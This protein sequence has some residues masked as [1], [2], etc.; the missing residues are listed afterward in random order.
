[1]RRGT[2]GNDRRNAETVQ[3]QVAVTSGNILQVYL[4]QKNGSERGQNDTIVDKVCCAYQTAIPRTH[5]IPHNQV[6]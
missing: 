5:A 1:M 4:E 2:D 3:P 6:P